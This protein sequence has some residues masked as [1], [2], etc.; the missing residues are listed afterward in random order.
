MKAVKAMSVI[1]LIFFG[2]GFLSTPSLIVEDPYA[3][4]GYGFFISIYALAFSIVALVN[5]NKIINK[6]K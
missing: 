2:I 1:G 4:A 5:S 3:A 6:Q